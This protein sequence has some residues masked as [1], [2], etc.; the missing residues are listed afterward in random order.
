[1]NNEQKITINALSYSPFGGRGASLNQITIMKTTKTKH[2]RPLSPFGGRGA[3]FFFSLLPLW[4]T[5][6]FSSAQ[7]AVSN[8]QADY[9]AKKI[10]FTVSWSATPENNKIWLLAD[11]RKIENNAESGSWSRAPI[12]AATKTAGVG[13]AATVSG[14]PQGFWLTTAGS[15]GSATVEATLT[16]PVNVTQFNWCAYAFNAPPKATF[17]LANGYALHGTKPFK[18]N[19]ADLAADVAVYSGDPPITA[20]TDATGCPG[21]W[22]PPGIYQLQGSCTFTQPPLVSTFAAFPTTYS[23]STF[24]TLMDERDGNNYTVV[25]IGGKWIMAQNLN[26]QKNL[27]WQANSNMPATGTGQN[28]ALIGHFWC[29]G[30]YSST[31]ATS[32]RASCDVWGALY[33]WETAMSFDGLGSWSEVATYSTGAA[34]AANSKFNHGRSASGS[35]TGGRGICPPNWHVPTDFEWGEILDGME[36]GGGT[37]HQNASGMGYFGTNAGSRGKAACTV[38]DNSTSGN[39]YVNDT[40]AN[41]YYYASTLG[42]DAYGFRILPAGY[43]Y[44]VSTY[45]GGRGE[46]SYLWSSASYH[47]NLSWMRL[48]YY[49]YARVRRYASNRAYGASV[50]CVRD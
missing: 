43:R 10:T 4:G 8:M 46:M 21:I 31:T 24:V 23:A 28:T 20:F 48:F 44:Q 45:M 34:N 13:S 1:M 42:T 25:K 36:S 19:G 29:P 14:N 41:W 16:L 6:G 26:Y 17:T 37:A 38:G 35:G 2:V 32:T 22:D 15:S 12:A 39:A 11:Y 30:G 27:T 33:S 47:E 7:V 9:A 3:L 5:G 50:R 40:Q 49:D 18:V